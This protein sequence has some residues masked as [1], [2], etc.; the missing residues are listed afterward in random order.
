[1]SWIR[2][3]VIALLTMAMVVGFFLG[4]VETQVFA[5]FATGLIIFWFKS[6]DSD[7]DRPA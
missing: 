7:K 2:P 6:R 4:Y 5:P 3:G 1:M